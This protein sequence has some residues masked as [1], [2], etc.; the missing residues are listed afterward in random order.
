MRWLHAG[1]DLSRPDHGDHCAERPLMR[2][3]RLPRCPLQRSPPRLSTHP[4]RFLA[5]LRPPS[6]SALTSNPHSARCPAGAQLPATSCLGAFWTPVSRACLEPRYCRRPK[7]CTIPDLALALRFVYEGRQTAC[8]LVGL[9]LFELRHQRAELLCSGIEGDQLAGVPE[10]CG[11]I[12]LVAR[13]RDE[14]HQDVAIRR[15]CRCA[16]SKKRQRLAP[17]TVEFSATA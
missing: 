11:K 9:A 16:C 6:R 3:E 1:S 13:D 5:V 12:P 10:C 4:G 2:S 15:M 17:P 14:R 7:T 8:P